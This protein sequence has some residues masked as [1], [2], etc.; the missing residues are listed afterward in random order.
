MADIKKKY[1]ASDFHL[2]FP[3]KE[4]SLVREKKIVAWLES[5]K[6]DADEI[7]LLGDLFD[8][9]YEYK[10]VVPRGFVRFLGKLTELTDAGIKV[11]ITR[12]NHDLWYK[13]YL[14]KEVGAQIIQQPVI[15]EWNGRQFFMHHGNALGKY[16]RG[17]NFLDKIFNNKFLQ[18]LF[19]RIHPEGAFSFAHKWSSHNRKVK[20]YESS[21]YLGDDK[22]WLLLYVKDKIK[23]E[24][25]DYFIFGHR[26]LAIDSIIEN[27]S[28]YVNLGNWITLSTYGVWDG[29]TFSLMEFN[30]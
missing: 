14:E 26:H 19:E 25:Y 16:D 4:E 8:F 17:I 3:S 6:H 10:W 28:H 9:W 15:R 29:E 2:G 27:G 23:T 24:H 18:F 7:Y 21:N 5:I 20:V 11:F 1:F 30:P 22:E 12:G 13:D